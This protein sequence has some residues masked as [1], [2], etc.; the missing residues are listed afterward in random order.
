MSRLGVFDSGLGGYDVLNHIHEKYPNQDLVYLADQK[1]VPYG[2]KSREELVEI[3]KENMAF[4]RRHRIKKVLIACNT[5][6]S[7]ELDF[8]GVESF[9]IIETTARTVKDD[10]VIVLATSFTVN[11]HV[12]RKYL[13]G[14]EVIEIALPGMVR[15]VEDG[16]SREEIMDE[17]DRNLHEYK[18]SGISVVLGC[19]HFPLVKKEIEEYLGGKTYESGTAVLAL[20]IYSTGKGRV[21]V[22]TSGDTA[23]FNE[24]VHRIYGQNIESKSSDSSR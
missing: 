15:L 4:F 17:L 6:S 21:E 10:K 12:Y 19:T 23:A 1:N 5:I 9:R 24:K 2:N 11:S 8:S 3:A 13:P 14:K 16:A 22:Y 7:L 20:P 18:N